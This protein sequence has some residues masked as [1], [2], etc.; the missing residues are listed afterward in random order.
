M[1]LTKAGCDTPRLDAELLLACAL[2]KD[3]TWLYVY[4]QATID[5]EP[6]K[7][8]FDFIA[9]REQREPV[10]YITGYK[11]FF[12]LQFQINPYVL[13]PRPE[14]ELLVETALHILDLKSKTQTQ[15]SK[16]NIVDVGTGSGC[17]AV[18]LARHLPRANLFAIDASVEALH[19]AQQNAD[20]HQV[21]GRITFLSGDLLECLPPAHAVDFIVSNPPYVSRPELTDDVLILPEVRRYEP[22]L[23]LDGG[24]DG[25]DVIR[26][27]IPQAKERL[28]P[29][30]ALLVEIGSGQGQ[31]ASQLSRTHFPRAEIQIKTDLAGLDRLLVVRS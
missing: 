5:Q 29:G 12:G 31:A 21:A 15:T 3:R 30:G 14:T 25:L 20:R 9:R 16:V 28:I 10:A 2:A 17:I 27:L 7:N 11:E 19:L 22:W 18:A 23:A 26:R 6:L 13:I 1:R 4:P 8:F 24:E